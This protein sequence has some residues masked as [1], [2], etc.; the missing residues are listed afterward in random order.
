MTGHRQFTAFAGLTRLFQNLVSR[1]GETPW[2]ARAESG[3]A[4]GRDAGGNARDLMD[5]G[6]Y[7]LAIVP[8]AFGRRIARGVL[9]FS[10]DHALPGRGGSEGGAYETI[11]V[12][13]SESKQRRRKRSVLPPWIELSGH[14]HQRLAGNDRR[15]QRYVLQQLSAKDICVDFLAADA[16]E[17]SC[18]VRVDDEHR[19][20]PSGK[21]ACPLRQPRDAAGRGRG[22]GRGE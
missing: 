4:I 17:Q 3:A 21:A 15:L 14:W 20:A 22:R 18:P 11:L 19:P 7:P 8:R 10:S 2:R 6:A 9:P 13:S 5:K 12:N 16:G 1:T